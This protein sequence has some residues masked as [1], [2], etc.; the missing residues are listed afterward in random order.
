MDLYFPGTAW[1]R[2][3]RDTA[4]ALLR[5]QA[6]HAIPTADEAL[7]DLLARPPEEDPL[8]PTPR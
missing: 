6:R 8:C 3:R 5:H 2:V 7:S 1:L 4:D